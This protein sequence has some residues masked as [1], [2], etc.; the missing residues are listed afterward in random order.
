MIA[1]MTANVIAIFI[2]LNIS[3]SATGTRNFKKI[4]QRVASNERARSSIGRSTEA[5]PAAV[6][7]TIGKNAIKNAMKILGK[8]P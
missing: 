6:L 3:G 2:P 5:R 7:T 4:C 1:P 8:S